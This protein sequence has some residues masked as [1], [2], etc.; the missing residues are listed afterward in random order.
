MIEKIIIAGAGGQGNLFLGKILCL[1]AIE[2]GKNATWLPSYGPAMR[3]GKSTCTVVISNEEIGSPIVS[4]PDT[5]IVMNKPSL[6]FM[7]NMK[8]GCVIINQSLAEYDGFSNGLDVIPIHTDDIMNQLN[9]KQ[10]LN[11]ILLGAYVNYKNV[12]KLGTVLRALGSELKK[13]GREKLF[14]INKKAIMA[15]YD[16]LG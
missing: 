15:G 14:E 8:K 12:V 13:A 4:V 11:M 6:D 9:S 1:T 16:Y 2:E 5:L 7:K 10:V 3:G